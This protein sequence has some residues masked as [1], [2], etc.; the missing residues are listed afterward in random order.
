MAAIGCWLADRVSSA[1][2]ASAF[3]CSCI[4]LPESETDSGDEHPQPLARAKK[5]SKRAAVAQGQEVSVK[6]FHHVEFYCSDAREA[7]QSFS[8][9]LGM[10]LVAKSNRNTSNHTYR[11]YA[12]KSNEV[13]F[14]FTSRSPQ[15]RKMSPTDETMRKMPHPGFS[16]DETR[17]FVAT[18][19]LAVK[20]LGILVDDVQVAFEKSVARGEI[21]A[22][23]PT[24][25][26]DEKTSG[27]VSIAEVRLCRDTIIRYV[28][29]HDFQG[30][31]L[32]NYE[33]VCLPSLSSSRKILGA[34]RLL[35]LDHVLFHSQN[36]HVHEH[37]E[38]SEEGQCPKRKKRSKSIVVGIE[39]KKLLISRLKN[40]CCP[41][42]HCQDS[43]SSIQYL[44]ILCDDI[45]KAVEEIMGSDLILPNSNVLNLN[46]SSL[47]LAIMCSKF[48]SKQTG[49][50]FEVV[51]KPS[52]TY[53]QQLREE[54]IGSMLTDEQL[55][56][57]EELGI[58]VDR[59]EQ[60]LRF[61]IL[62]KP[63]VKRYYN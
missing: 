4:V 29:N 50:K 58:M 10:H 49:W 6:G 3:K 57:C 30:P 8:S 43:G 38:I 17:R 44:A 13:T 31:F 48:Q 21:P 20:A 32:P 63:L 23:K 26:V 9:A 54:G 25:L 33:T 46:C 51:G 7:Y 36:H 37:G 2:M 11:S 22:F 41:V 24:V 47:N 34:H 12:I 5:P 61:H 42:E 18:H 60:G 16:P 19:G 53:Y 15:T 56:K 52:S 14:V 1:F 35:R 39:K 62:I 27:K 59:D 45:F 55:V 28:T 40:E